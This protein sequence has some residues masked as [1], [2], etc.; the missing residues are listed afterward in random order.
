M[1]S[2]VSGLVVILFSVQNVRGGFIFVCSDVPRQVSLSCWD[3]FVCR[4][5]LGHNCSVK[6]KLEFKRDENVS[7]EV[8]K[9]CYLG[10]MNSCEAVSARIAWR[11]FRELHGVL[12]GKQGLSLKQQ[13]NIYQCCVRP[14]LLYCCETWELTV[15]DE[16]RLHGVERCMIRMM[17]GVKLVDRVLT[18]VLCNRVG[19]VGKIENMTIQ[20]RLQ[21]YG[22][23]M[24]GDINFQI[25]EVMEVKITGK[26]KKG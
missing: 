17:C 10:D 26:K 5:C 18:D 19:V 22:H 20:T 24:H 6:E 23:V 4:T 11:K 21:W 13:G 9:F 2:V 8:E 1:V 16:A 12:V 14:V 15:A 25:R 3:V 7:E